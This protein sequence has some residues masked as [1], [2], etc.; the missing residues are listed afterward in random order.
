MIKIDKSALE[1]PVDKISFD[2]ALEYFSG[3]V[4]E[5]FLLKNNQRAIVVSDRISA[6]DF[7]LGTVP[8]KGQILNKIANFWFRE[9]DKIN[10]PHH[11]ISEPHPNVSLVKNVK[12]L[13]IEIIVRG[14]LTGSTTTSSW[15]AYQNNN[16]MISGIKMKDGMKKNE[17]FPENILTPTTK[18]EVGHDRNISKEEILEEGLVSVEVYEKVESYAL[19][20]FEYGQ[21]KAAEKGLILVDTKYEM[22]ITESGELLVIDEV[23]TPDSSRYWIEETYKERLEKNLEPQSLDKEFVRNMLVDSGY[24]VDNK[25]QDPK[26]FMTEEIRLKAAE[27]YMALYE[28]MTG[29]SF[30]LDEGRQDSQSIIACLKTL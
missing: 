26:D 19:K 25:D 7:I 22:G 20:M 23:H 3:K 24:N 10:I 11:L 12:P 17:K 18:P 30:V 21:K 29:E 16:K 8:Y 9:L 4:R 6:F 28:K 27:K 1:N 5:T 2:G 13:P 15:Y 14:Y